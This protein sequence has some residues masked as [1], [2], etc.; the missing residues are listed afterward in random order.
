[1]EV[2]IEYSIDEHSWIFH[3]RY[4][5]EK[6]LFDLASYDEA[7]W[8]L[9]ISQDIKKFGPPKSRFGLKGLCEFSY[10]CFT[11]LELLKKIEIFNI[12]SNDFLSLF[13]DD[14]EIWQTV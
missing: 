13:S 1:M 7:K 14:L 9:N 2:F 6:V 4:F 5:I 3:N 12:K 8:P 11:K 10:S